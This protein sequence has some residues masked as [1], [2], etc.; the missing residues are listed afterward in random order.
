[1]YKIELFFIPPPHSKYS[2]GSK[3][4][5]FIVNTV[6]LVMQQ[7]DYLAR[8]TGLNAKGFSGDTRV[9]SW[10]NKKW[11]S[12]IEDTPVKLNFFF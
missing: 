6:P 5:I 10:D 12:E 9:K 3:R 1:M 8:H 11:R 4:T 2:S 7:T